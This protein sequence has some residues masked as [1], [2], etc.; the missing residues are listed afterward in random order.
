MTI[1]KVLGNA[2]VI[3]HVQSLT[4]TCMLQLKFIALV[5]NKNKNQV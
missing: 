3:T 2:D 4:E 5:N 1:G